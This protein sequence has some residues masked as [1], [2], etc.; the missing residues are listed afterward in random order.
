LGEEGTGDR[1]GDALDEGEN[2]HGGEDDESAYF[3]S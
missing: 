3:S 1:L 2:W